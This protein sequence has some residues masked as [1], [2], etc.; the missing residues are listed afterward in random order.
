MLLLVVGAGLPALRRFALAVRQCPDARQ[1]DCGIGLFLACVAIA[2]DGLFSGNF[3]MPVS[4]VWIAF[5]FGWAMAWM[6]SQ[7]GARQ[8][9]PTEGGGLVTLGGSPRSG[10]WLHSCGWCGPCGP[11]FAISMSTSSRPWSEFPTP[12]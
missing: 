11:K 1:R 5:T 6:A 4:Q 7:R 3:V 10:C 2:V 8:A 9:A 12:R